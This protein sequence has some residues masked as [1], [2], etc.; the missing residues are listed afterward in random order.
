[1]TTI[2]TST[3]EVIVRDAFPL[4]EADVAVIFAVPTAIAVARP[5]GEIEAALEGEELHVTPLSV[6]CDLSLNVPI[7]LNCCVVPLAIDA[8]PGE[9]AIEASTGAIAEAVT[10]PLTAPDLAVIVDE[11][12]ATEVAKP[13]EEIVTT[14][15]VSEDHMA[16]LL[17]SW[18]VP[19]L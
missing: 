10:D 18:V 4:V 5:A 6:C 11:P 1:V 16:E 13:V 15:T 8:D 3:A 12:W 9:T 2:D 7:A 14:P 17:K 19:S